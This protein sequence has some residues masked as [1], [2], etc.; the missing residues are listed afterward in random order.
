MFELVLKKIE[1]GFKLSV[2]H[3]KSVI[4]FCSIII[5][6]EALAAVRDLNGHSQKDQILRC[7][8]LP[9]SH[10][11]ERNHRSRPR[12]VLNYTYKL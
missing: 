12:L 7:S 3:M 8:F 11:N 9:D 5:A 2:A 1:I 10:D 4:E 6:Q